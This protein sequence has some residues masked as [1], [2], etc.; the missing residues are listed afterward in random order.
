MKLAEQNHVGAQPPPIKKPLVKRHWFEG[1][2]LTVTE[3]HRLVSGLSR[4][5]VRKH[6]SAGRNTRYLMLSFDTSKRRSKNGQQGSVALR[7]IFSR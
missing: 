4:T 5:T 1:Q 2:L 3:I 7:K 6:L